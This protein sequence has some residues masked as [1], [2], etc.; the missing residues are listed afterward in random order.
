MAAGY[1]YLKEG[2]VGKS[3]EKEEDEEEEEEEEEQQ[4]QQ[5]QLKNK[6]LH[7]LFNEMRQKNMWVP[8]IPSTNIAVSEATVRKF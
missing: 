2:S 4:Q 6:K 8:C 5:Q 1:A 7:A 3:F